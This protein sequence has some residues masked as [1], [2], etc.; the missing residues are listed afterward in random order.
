MSEQNI[1]SQNSLA[2]T[3]LSKLLEANK[4]H[5]LMSYKGKDNLPVYQDPFKEYRISSSISSKEPILT[6][7]NIS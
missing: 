2:D 6:K 1:S 5:K 3:D 4:W 7:G